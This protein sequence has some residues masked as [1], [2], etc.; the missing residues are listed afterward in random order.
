VSLRRLGHRRLATGVFLKL[1]RRYVIDGQGRSAARDVLRHPGGVGVL[2]VHDEHVFLVSQYRTAVDSEVLEIP[3]GKLDPADRNPLLAA[4][5][6]LAE[7]IGATAREW[8]LLARML[9]SPGYTDEVLHL[10]AATGLDTGLRKPHGAEEELATIVTCRLEEALDR[11]ESGEIIDAKT[12]I[13]LL[14][15][16]RTRRDA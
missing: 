16:A 14:L 10:Y 5:R 15:W 13:A 3:A 1:D 2:P 12:Q 7:E 11:I 9:P 6:E 8:R 4:K